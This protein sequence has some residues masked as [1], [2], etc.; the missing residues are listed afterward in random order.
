MKRRAD[1]HFVADV[2]SVVLGRPARFSN[3]D[4]D[5][6][7][8]Q[9]RLERAARLAGF[10]EIEFFAEPIAAAHGYARADQVGGDAP[11]REEIVFAADFGGGTSDFTLYRVRSDARAFEGSDVLAM[12]GVSVAGDALDSGIMRR[13]IAPHFGTGVKYQVPFGSNILTMPVHLMERICHPAEIS[14]LGRRDTYEF[15]KNVQDWALGQ[16]DRK[17]MKRL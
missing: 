4:A 12:G 7:F 16:E 14:L 11:L 3:D 5:D 17:K 1:V 13:R 2:R 6:R 10:T 8:A 15:L 9:D